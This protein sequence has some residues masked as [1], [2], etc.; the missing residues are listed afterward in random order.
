MFD[1][2][3]DLNEVA[4][5]IRRHL[6]RAC[7]DRHH[8]MRLAWVATVGLDGSASTRMAVIRRTRFAPVKATIFTDRRARKWAEIGANPGGSLGLFDRKAMEQLR[9]SGNWHR[10]TDAAITRPL[11]EGQNATARVLY[12]SQ[13]PGK[14]IARQASGR[15]QD[16]FAN[17]GVLE[18]AV[19]EI[20][21][22]FL[23]RERHYR[24]IFDCTGDP[25]TGQW[26]N[27]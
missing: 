27:P 20:D 5:R 22:L 4:A 18:L 10:Q 23:D 14:P 25:W 19:G 15:D 6:T 1:I 21:W 3:S 11:W 2:P 26:V 17:F 16:G 7:A 12:A 13:P 24:A 8:P 9:L